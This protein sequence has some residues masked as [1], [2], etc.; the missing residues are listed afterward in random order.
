[1]ELETDKGNYIPWAWTQIL[2]ACMCAG[3]SF[4]RDLPFPAVLAAS[5]VVMAIYRL[6]FRWTHEATPD[7]NRRM[8]RVFSLSTLAALGTLTFTYPL[9]GHYWINAVW[10]SFLLFRGLFGLI[11]FAGQGA[12]ASTDEEGDDSR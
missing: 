11:L 2:A 1:V 9:W 7:E 8:L 6:L 5:L 10:A 3:L 4:I 12:E